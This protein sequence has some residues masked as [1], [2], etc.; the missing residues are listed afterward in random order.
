MS[1]PRSF[2]RTWILSLMAFAVLVVSVNLLADPYDVFGTPRIAGFNARKPTARDHAMLTKTYQVARAHPATVVI[3]SSP[4]YLGIDAFSPAWPAAMR[5]VYNYGIPGGYA[6]LASL[7]TLREAIFA[8]GVKDAVVFLDFQNFLVPGGDSAAVTEES[9]RFRFAPD[10]SPNPYRPRQMA[11]DMFLALGTM[12]ALTDSLITVARQEKPVSLDMARDGSATEADFINAANADGMH[13]MFAQKDMFEAER[14]NRSKR[15]IAGWTGPLPGL[16]IVSRMIRVAH[17]HHVKLTLVIAPHHFDSLELYWRDGLWPRIEQLK[18]ELA[19]LAATPDHDVILWDFMDYGTF[20]TEDVPLVGD[21]R[22]ET[23]WFWEPTHFK[24]QVGSIMIQRMF[25]G[26][27]PAFGAALTQAN[28]AARNADVRTERQ[29]VVC[30][31]D[32]KR[33]L[34]ALDKPPGDGCASNGVVLRQN[35]PT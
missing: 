10:G 5:P 34:T 18:T 16:D 3:G 14:A 8:G 2:L 33:P 27:G 20:T 9:R 4:V 29:A 32:R 6:T 12:S 17:A 1:G 25:D 31:P 19:A 15:A 13:D 21:R 22:T 26:D 28:V 7:E 35:G 23:H 11:E 30:G 24:K